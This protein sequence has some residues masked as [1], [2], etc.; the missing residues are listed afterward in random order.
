[1]TFFSRTLVLAALALVLGAAGC[2]SAHP[3][4]TIR[5]MTD[6]PDETVTYDMAVY[7]LARNDKVQVFLFKR[8][9]A[10]I[11]MADADFEYVFFE[12]P[13]TSSYGWL[14]EDDV[15]VYRWIRHDGRNHVWVGNAG[16]ASQFMT[17]DKTS[18]TFKFQVTLE[19]TAGTAGGA[20]IL[21]GRVECKEDVVAAQGLLNRYGTW[22]MS[23]LG[24]PVPKDAA[25]TKTKSAPKAKTPANM[26]GP[27]ESVDSG[28]RVNAH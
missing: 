24:K 9:A 28:K 8:V 21:N 3:Q 22:L 2:S 15:P 16:Q 12:L 10:P 13:E 20:Y 17:D 18:M 19:P 4:A 7:Q 25:P 1:M 26:K 6:G 23:V 11:G 5:Y 27:S 14:K